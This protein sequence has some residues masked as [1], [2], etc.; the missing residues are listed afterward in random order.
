MEK[1]GERRKGTL[2]TLPLRL[3]VYMSYY[4]SPMHTHTHT[5]AY[6]V[7]D[8]SIEEC[9]GSKQTAGRA[10]G[11]GGGVLTPT[12]LPPSSQYSNRI[13]DAGAKALA[14]AI[15][16]GHLRNL[17]GLWL[18]H[19]PQHLALSFLVLLRAGVA[20]CCRRIRERAIQ[21]QHTAGLSPEGVG[22]IEA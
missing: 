16:E 1:E 20:L 21:E 7:R 12:S 14:E 17:T 4:L 10:G 15:K 2:C 3:S 5:I 13:G 9:S 6:T 8:L 22:C 18:V 19:L 11:G